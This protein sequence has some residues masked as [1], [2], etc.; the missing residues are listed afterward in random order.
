MLF[1]LIFI[2]LARVLDVSL[3][4]V[5]MILVIR[6]DRIP[7]A[8]IGFFEILIYTVALGL[9]IGSLNE[10]LKLLVFCSGFAL[11]ILL[12]SILEEKIALGYR[13]VQVTIDSEH[14]HIV[15]ELREEGFPVTC[16]E[17]SGKAGSK[18]VLNIFLKRNMA[19]A[20]ADK[21]YEKDP[22]AFVVFMEPKHFQGGYIKKK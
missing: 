18:L 22:D 5:R 12:G 1:E 6:G 21:I 15:E 14:G 8:I 16:W 2:F 3:G 17:A 20:V 19:V 10:P 4:T 7:A 13:G 11:G 9:V